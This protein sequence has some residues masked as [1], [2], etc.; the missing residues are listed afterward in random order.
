[1]YTGLLHTHGLLR[2]IVLFLAVWVV[3]RYLIGWL[4]KQNFTHADNKAGLFFILGMHSQLLLG[5]LLYF[6]FSPLS[7]AFFETEGAMGI[8]ELRYWGVEHILGMVVSIALA[9]VGRTMSKRSL[10][11]ELKFKRGFI[12]YGL[13]L[14]IM[15]LMIP[16]P[17][18][19]GIGRPFFRF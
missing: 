11:H 16:W 1:M 6:F 7:K 14:F 17:W 8:R 19:E 13:S 3:V 9:Q 15:L 18:M 12:F 4:G 2:W 10:S 5:L